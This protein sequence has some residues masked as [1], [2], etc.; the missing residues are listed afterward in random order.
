MRFLVLIDYSDMDA[1]ARTVDAHR[2]YVGKGREE[3]NVADSGPFL[4]G[5]GGMYV[6]EVKDE[7]AAK[8]FVAGDPYVK[9]GRLRVSIRAYK[10]AL[11]ASST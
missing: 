9:D 3:G 7:A 8:A 2:A 6:L 4:D 10:S 11:D 1:R 5:A